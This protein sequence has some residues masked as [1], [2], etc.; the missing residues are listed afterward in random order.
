[1]FEYTSL[2]VPVHRIPTR[3]KWIQEYGIN[4]EKDQPELGYFVAGL[5]ID[6]LKN[7]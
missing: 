7:G 5:N 6:I 1:L 4:P 3:D 2:S